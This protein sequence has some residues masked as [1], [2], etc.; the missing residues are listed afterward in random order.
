MNR[1]TILERIG[2]TKNGSVPKPGGQFDTFAKQLQNAIP[3]SNVR[4]FRKNA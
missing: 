3:L 2:M 4:I 1:K